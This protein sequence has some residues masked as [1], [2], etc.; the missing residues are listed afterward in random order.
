[1]IHVLLPAVESLPAELC[2]SARWLVW[3]AELRGEKVAKIPCD[4]AGKTASM[5]DHLSDLSAALHDARTLRAGPGGACFGVGYCFGERCGLICLDLDGAIGSDHLAWFLENQPTWGEI[6]LSGNGAHLFYRGEFDGKRIISIDG[7]KIEIFGTRGFI[8]ITGERIPGSAA[9]LS[10]YNPSTLEPYLKKTN[11]NTIPSYAQKNEANRTLARAR[12]YLMAIPGAVAGSGGHNATYH[13]A[14]EMVEG[15]A[16]DAADALTLL[17]EWNQTCI[18]PWSEREL[19]HK[20]ASAVKNCGPIRGARIQDVA[21]DTDPEVDLSQWGKP[22]EDEVEVEDMPRAKNDPGPFPEHLLNVPGFIGEVMAYTR[23]RSFV[24]QP[25]LALAGAI[26]LM[27]VLAGRKIRDSIGSRTNLYLL[28]VARTGHGKDAARKSNKEI[29]YAA[30]ADSLIGPEGLASSAGL[31][32]SMQEKLAALFQLDEIGRLLATTGNPLANS[33]LYH[34]VTELLKFYTSADSIYLGN[35]YGDS[36]KNKTIVQPCAVVYGTTV[37]EPLYAAFNPDSVSSGWLGRVMVFEAPEKRPEKQTPSAIQPPDSVVE[38]ARQ[39]FNFVPG[40]NLGGTHPDP[41]CVECDSDAETKMQEFDRYADAEA[42]KAGAIIGCLWARATEKVRKLALIHSASRSAPGCS[43]I[44]AEAATW[45]SELTDYLTRRLCYIASW[46]IVENDSEG[47][48][49]R[50]EKIISDAG[51]KGITLKRLYDKTRWAT[52]KQRQEA[53]EHL[54]ISGKVRTSTLK[55]GG[56]PVTMF[57][58]I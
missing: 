4:R 14:M 41:H 15:F 17:S 42:D 43:R 36:E 55:S 29:L 44:D 5:K 26:S 39:W 24:D 48:I 10:D 30:G 37:P 2:T 13:A 51:E 28:G 35:A 49:L 34:I 45:A 21:G 33:H 16:L 9:V 56:R 12:A 23:A 7:A 22:I 57:V 54:G 50:I 52:K 25:I 27:A 31:V 18:P 32:T 47:A 3:R 19:A 8:A 46:N 1:M 20:I 40:G 53:L 11:S 6:S 38:F 58:S